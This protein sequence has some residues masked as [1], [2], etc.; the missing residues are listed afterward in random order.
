VGIGGGSGGDDLVSYTVFVM[1]MKG[2]GHP[3]AHRRRH[4]EETEL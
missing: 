2:K 4:R 3:V 1:V